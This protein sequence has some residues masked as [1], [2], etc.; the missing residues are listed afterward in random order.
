MKAEILM[1]LIIMIITYIPL[2]FIQKFSQRAVFYGVRIPIG[3]EKKEEL[4]KED[5]NY[6]K[7]LNMC[8]LVTCIL[9]ILIGIK[10]SEEY[11]PIILILGVFLV[12]FEGSICFYMVNK[13]VKI[14][15]KRENWGDLLTDENVVVVDIKAKNRNYEK[16]SK[17]YFTPPILLFMLVFFM[18]LS[19]W[20]KVEIIGLISFLFAIIVLFFSFL[21]INKSKQNLNGGNVK[22]IRVQNMKFRRIMSKFIILITY[23]ISILFTVTNLGNMNLISHEKE[24]VITTT[25][26]I[27]IIILSIALI[28]YSYKAGQSGKNIAI[29]K[30]DGDK[31]TLT[32]N[33][34]DDDNYIFGM[35][36][37]NPNDPAFFV[38]KRAGVGWTINV[39]RPMGKVAMALTA[40][41]IIGTIVMTVYTSTSMK[42]NL[43][44]REQV[45][46]IKGMY[47]ENINGKDIV[48][49]SFEESI[50]PIA[51][52]QNGAA[53]GSKKLGYFRTKDGEKV[54]LFIE[55]DKNSVIKIATKEKTIYLNYEEEEKTEALFNELKNLKDK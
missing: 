22:D 18:A 32:I 6:K 3:F 33:R 17:W 14:I 40:L 42:V 41:L 5:K 11:W 19:N 28:I 46:A 15:K 2:L 52:K 45:V 51:V 7:N 37:Y 4:M 35:I 10:I 44:I 47:S 34:E 26:I 55:D 21:S 50:P 20:K 30:D 38:E 53:I 39:A 29:E 25:M 54:K 27:F 9:S 24:F 8:F 43:Q 12:I 31:D 13:R 49:L 48:Q 16:L 23:V 1:F 36:Y